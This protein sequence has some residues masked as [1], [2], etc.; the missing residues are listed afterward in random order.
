MDYKYKAIIPNILT[1]S[2]IILTPIIILFSILGHIKISVILIIIASI[3]DLFD[4]MLARKW[5]VVSKKGAKLDAVADKIFVIGIVCTI[6]TKYKFYIPILILE[7]IIA[8]MNLYFYAK[9]KIIKSLWV[10]KFK[11]TVL[12]VSMICSIISILVIDLTKFTQALAIV[13]IN[14]QVLCIIS[15]FIYHVKNKKPTIEDNKMHQQ[16]MKEEFDN[17]IVLNNLSDIE[18]S[19]YDI[20][21]DDIF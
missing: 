8:I 6:I 17:T 1:I 13:T 11:T 4:G 3:T 20:E 2:R 19:I 21:K 18:E 12:F 15:Y 10:G 9:T 7:V 5:N 16:I 14:L